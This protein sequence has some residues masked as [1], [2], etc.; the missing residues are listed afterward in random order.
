MIYQE[1]VNYQ[2][3]S[4]EERTRPYRGPGPGLW[5]WI[6]GG[7]VLLLLGA[8]AGALLEFYG[9]TNVV[10]GFGKGGRPTIELGLWHLKDVPDSLVAAPYIDELVEQDLISGYLN[11]EFKPQRPITRAEFAA[12]VNRAF[13]QQPASEPLAFEDVPGDF[14]GQ[15]AIANA[16]QAGFFVGYGDDTFRPHQPLTHWE[17]LT[18]LQQG[19]GIDDTSS[20]LRGQPQFN[21]ADPNQPLTRAEAAVLVYQTQDFLRQEA[22]N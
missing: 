13:V 6:G 15:D 21:Q 4:P 7:I 20:I 22:E 14:W 9:I 11:D 18:A 12:L 19:L 10:S 3:L 5:E 17:A 2:H 8:G 1:Q 16:S